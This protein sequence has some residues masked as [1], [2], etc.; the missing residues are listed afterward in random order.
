LIV[1]KTTNTANGKFYVGKDKHDDPKY[2]GSGTILKLAIKKYGVES[3]VKEVLERCDETNLNER[4]VFWIEKLEPPYNIAAGGAGGDVMKYAS[5]ERKR[6]YSE[7]LSRSMRERAKNPTDAML[8]KGKKISAAKKGVVF[9]KEHL[10]RLSKSH[11]GNE[12]W[13]L[14]KKTP[15]EVVAKVLVQVECPH[16]GKVGQRPAMGR[17]HF[18][19]C[20]E[21]LL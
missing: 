14:G 17:W 2:L 18:D 8:N 13:N 19:N 9:T 1:Y 16:C 21:R 7:K 10:E 20:K 12:P 3:F 6:K 15:P 4:E 11:M 5:E